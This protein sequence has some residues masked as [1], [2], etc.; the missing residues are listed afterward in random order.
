MAF[1]GKPTYSYGV[2]GETVR[3]KFA[4]NVA[5]HVH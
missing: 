5:L 2:G 4:K 3:G 1:K